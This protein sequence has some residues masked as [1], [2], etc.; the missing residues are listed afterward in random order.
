MI[1]NNQIMNNKLKYYGFIR[2]LDNIR[3]CDIYPVI[4][5]SRIYGVSDATGY[6]YVKVDFY[7]YSLFYF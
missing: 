3:N 7:K 6:I 2:N 4:W 5:A 1:F